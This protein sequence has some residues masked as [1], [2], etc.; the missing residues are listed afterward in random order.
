MQQRNPLIGSTKDETLTNAIEA[1]NELV[2]L[3][4][5]RH[6]PLTTLMG[7]IVHALECA[8]SDHVVD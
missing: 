3:M 7:P 6:G 2:I 8:A 5:D 1:L 4:A